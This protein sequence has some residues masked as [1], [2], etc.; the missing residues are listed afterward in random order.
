M[1]YLGYIPELRHT[2]L[3]GRVANW[4]TNTSSTNPRD[5][6]QGLV[7]SRRKVARQLIGLGATRATA[8]NVE[9]EVIRM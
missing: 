6:R 8:P 7:D 1:M 2:W 3:S 4:G 9:V 5:K